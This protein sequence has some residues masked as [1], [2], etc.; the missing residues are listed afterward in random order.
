MIT[1]KEKIKNVEKEIEL[2]NV[3]YAP[4]HK[5]M[6]E[7]E[8]T[9]EHLKRQFDIGDKVHVKETCHRGCCDETSIFGTIS[10]VE[11]EEYRKIYHYTVREDNT[12]KETRWQGHYN[13]KRIE[14]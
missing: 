10:D 1:F 7:L 14:D 12:E 8:R 9:L 11:F 2:L 4:L 13:I 3:V 5:N 6:E